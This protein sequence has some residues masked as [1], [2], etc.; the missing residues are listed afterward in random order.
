MRSL[1]VFLLA[2]IGTFIIDQELKRLFLDGYFL[3]SNCISLELHLNR[4]VAFSMLSFLGE[5]LKWLQLLLIIGVF[6]LFSYE[7]LLKRFPF[8]TGLLMGGALGN[9]YDRFTIGAVVDFIYWHCGFKFAVFNY[10]D[11]MINIAIFL[12]ILNLWLENKKDKL[13][14]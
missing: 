3:E 13:N 9:L 11:T 5:W 7:G 14:R 10:A 4:G 6:W 8:I 2:T 12:L 1:V